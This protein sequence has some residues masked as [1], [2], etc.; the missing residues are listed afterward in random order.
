[1]NR[2]SVQKEENKAA[3]LIMKEAQV[4]AGLLERNECARCLPLCNA[5]NPFGM[6]PVKVG[7]CPYV[8]TEGAGVYT[9]DNASQPSMVNA[10]E[11]E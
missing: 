6:S 9:A 7:N 5:G 1:M 10:I 2:V 4:A 11:T 3:N 8:L